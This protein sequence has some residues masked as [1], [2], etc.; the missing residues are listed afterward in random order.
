MS[1]SRDESC[2]KC[3]PCREGTVR[4]LEILDRIVTGQGVLEDLNKLK[5]LGRLMQ[6]AS[7]CGLGRACAN[8]VLSTI[9]YYEKEYISHIVD[10]KCEAKC[11]SMCLKEENFV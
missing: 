4:M 11:C 10:K 6:R 7:L 8:P 3:T 9:K 2:G 1:F 5:R